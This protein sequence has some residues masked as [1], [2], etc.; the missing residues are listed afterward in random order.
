MLIVNLI[1]GIIGI[2]IGIKDRKSYLAGTNM[3]FGI[4]NIIIGLFAP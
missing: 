1:I 2:S 4:C 3:G